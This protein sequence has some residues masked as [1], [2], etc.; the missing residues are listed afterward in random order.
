MMGCNG[1]AGP[2]RSGTPG[3]APALVCTTAGTTTLSIEQL[4]YSG[5]NGTGTGGHDLAGLTRIEG[6]GG[7]WDPGSNQYVMTY[8]DP[9]CGYC[10]G[11]GMGYAT[12]PTLYGTW[13]APVG[14]AA[15]G[16]VVTGRRDVSATSC[17]GQPRTLSVVD[18]LP[19]QVIDL[20]NGTRNEATANTELVPLRYQPHAGAA[21]DGRSW[22]PPLALT[23]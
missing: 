22:T 10:T 13:S 4:G 7:W 23:C 1:P 12:A 11:T 8:S 6:V 9:G 17:G 3:Q 20:W 19:W 5:V 16:P 15:A 14:L 18:G 21:G 2:F